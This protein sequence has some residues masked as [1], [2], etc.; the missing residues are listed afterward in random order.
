MLG[1]HKNTIAANCGSGY[2]IEVM[3]EHMEKA[4][5]VVETKNPWVCE[6]KL[7]C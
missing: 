3:R 5:K 1:G 6:F 7:E 2:A 4:C